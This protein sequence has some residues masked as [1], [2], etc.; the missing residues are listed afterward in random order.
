MTIM[1]KDVMNL[2]YYLNIVRRLPITSG[3]DHVALVAHVVAL[4]PSYK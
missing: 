4:I 2:L 1:V 3:K